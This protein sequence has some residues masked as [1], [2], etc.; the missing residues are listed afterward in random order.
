MDTAVTFN[1]S[2]TD[3]IEYLNSS[4]STTEGSSVEGTFK[5]TS[6]EIAKLIQTIIRP[7]L[8]MVGTVGNCLTIYIMRRTSLKHLSTCFYMFLL[9]VADTCK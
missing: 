4:N 6:E 1:Y 8:I 5:W 9:A 3:F 2:E 7:I